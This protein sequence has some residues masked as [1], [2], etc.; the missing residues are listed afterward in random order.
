M[1]ETF[2]KLIRRA[3][4]T[5]AIVK[6]DPWDIIPIKNKKYARDCTEIHLGNRGIEK[7]IRFEDFP[8]LEVLWIN[9][10]K[11]NII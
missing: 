9:N 5:K 6:G 10:N 2:N 11:V 8:N 1:D 7:L 4:E 3:N